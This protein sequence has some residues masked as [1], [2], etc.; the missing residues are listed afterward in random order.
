MSWWIAR[1]AGSNIYVRSVSGDDYDTF[2]AWD[3]MVDTVG[4]EYS[5]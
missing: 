1:T 4:T 2:G 3:D 5:V